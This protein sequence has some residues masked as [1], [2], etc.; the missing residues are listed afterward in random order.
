MR[1][2][3]ASDVT[4]DPFEGIKRVARLSWEQQSPG[5]VFVGD[6]PGSTDQWDKT[7][8]AVEG[9]FGRGLKRS[10]PTPHES[11]G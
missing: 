4:F 7:S 3:C 6:F 11:A 9:G 10:L 5:I 8:A 1:K 2:S